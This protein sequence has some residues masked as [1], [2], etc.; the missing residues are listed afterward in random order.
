MIEEFTY[1]SLGA[2]VQSSALL[3]MSALGLYDCPR[4]D[5]AVFADVGDEPQWVY[6]YLRDHLVPFGDKH[7]IPVE[8]T[9]YGHLS[10]DYLSADGRSFAS[11]PL[12]LVGPNGEHGMLRRQCTEKYKIRPIHRHIRQHLGYKPRQRV[13]EKV[14]SLHGISV[15]EAHR[16]RTSPTKWV[17]LG[18]PL[19]DANLNRSQCE[20]IVVGAGLPK[21][22]RSACVFCP[23]HSDVYWNELK[24]QHPNEFG[25]AIEFDKA[26]RHVKGRRGIGYLHASRKPLAEVDF[27]P[28]RDQVDMFG[29]DCSGVC[30]V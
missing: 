30:G 2:G 29:N 28:N 3:V 6:D 9:Q 23:F 12:F 19:V 11:P 24:T 10:K 20:A 15:D 26:I 27:K 8:T 5:L 17:Q 21:P 14:L 18:Y 4:A 22:E 13:K 25:R 7:G 1:L 16:M